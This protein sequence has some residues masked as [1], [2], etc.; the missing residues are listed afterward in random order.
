MFQL[1]LQARVKGEGRK[2]EARNVPSTNF[3]SSGL[4]LP[5]T[6]SWHKSVAHI[7]KL[8]KRGGTRGKAKYKLST[9]YSSSCKIR[10]DS[11]IDGGVSYTRISQKH[12]REGSEKEKP[13]SKL[14]KQNPKQKHTR[15]VFNTTYHC[16]VLH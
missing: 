5:S 9:T 7:E 13:T 12:N 16:T 10:N 2:L 6:V 15:I 14:Q 11:I 4:K 3:S 1:L 8:P